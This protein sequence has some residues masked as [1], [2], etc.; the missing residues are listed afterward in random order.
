MLKL[1]T[2]YSKKIPAETEY[3]SQSYH[4]TLELELPDGLTQ[5][6]LAE[7]VHGVF[8]FVRQSVESELHNAA[9]PAQMPAQS[10]IPQQATT[11][12][13]GNGYAQQQSYYE[14]VP[15]PQVPPQPQAVQQVQAS[16]HQQYNG[17][18]AGNGAATPKQ[19]NYLLSLAKRAGW[20]VQQ[21]L[22]QC[23]VT[24]VEQLSAKTCSQLIEQLAGK[25]A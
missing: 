10:V 3:S 15:Q 7:K 11:A 25:A 23:N 21:I 20:N 12:A 24:S 13:K 9:A 4:C 8:E 19:L 6:Q 14:P 17:K 18:H 5:Q 22:Q 2:A 16:P 1:C